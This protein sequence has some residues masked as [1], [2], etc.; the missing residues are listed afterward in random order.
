ML[1]SLCWFFC[2][3]HVL[4]RFLEGLE[5]AVPDVR[6]YLGGDHSLGSFCLSQGS[7]FLQHSYRIIVFFGLLLVL[8]R[9]CVVVKLPLL[10]FKGRLEMASF[11]AVT[12]I[13]CYLSRIYKRI[14]SVSAWLFLL[15]AGL[16][17]R[18]QVVL[19]QRLG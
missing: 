2:F 12:L 15:I 18:F 1:L 17:L 16:I 3:S 5:V 19:L 11:A 14:R 10:Q 8:G 6:L 7:P 9:K 4:L 13:H